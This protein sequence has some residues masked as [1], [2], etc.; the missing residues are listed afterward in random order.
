MPSLTSSS[1]TMVNSLIMKSVL[2]ILLSCDRAS[3]HVTVHR[4]NFPYNKTN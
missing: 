1:S 4:D 2:C 3:W